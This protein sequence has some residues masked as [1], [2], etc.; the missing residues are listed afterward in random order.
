MKNR[1][2]VQQPAKAQKVTK[3][4]Q[5]VFASLHALENAAIAA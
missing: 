2:T 4:Y 5:F 1:K 3:S